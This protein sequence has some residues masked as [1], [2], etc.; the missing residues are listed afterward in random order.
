MK[1][2][3][4]RRKRH[5]N[6][7]LVLLAVFGL[8]AVFV[9]ID[10]L[11]QASRGFH[12]YRAGDRSPQHVGLTFCGDSGLTHA[13]RLG[14]F[15]SSW[16]ELDAAQSES[17]IRVERELEQGF[18]W[19]RDTCDAFAA[20]TATT[21]LP[22]RLEFAET[23]MAAGLEALRAVRPAFEAFY[24]TLD[25]GQRQQLETVLNHRGASVR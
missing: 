17:W 6:I 1:S 12:H 14:S 16:L 18:I 22:E 24:D 10:P 3:Q 13:D 23:A 11:A 21:T 7:V 5:F 19:L 20:D 2:S 25:D 15:L 8:A 9:A 4:H